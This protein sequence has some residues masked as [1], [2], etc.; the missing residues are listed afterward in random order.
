[1]KKL[2]IGTMFMGLASLGISQVSNDL[3]E[4]VKLSD[5]TI[6]PLNMEY[7]DKV[8]DGPKSE[9]VFT[10][11][12]KASRYNI[13]ESPFFNQRGLNMIH[14]A[15]NKGNILATYDDNG[16]IVSANE[17]YKDLTPPPAVRNAVYKQYPGWDIYGNVYLVSYHHKNGVKKIYKI[18]IRKDGQKKK[19][20]FDF[21]G[22][23]I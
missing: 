8:H 13:K 16:K 11:E 20:R 1:M 7:L 3:L 23:S 18:Q 15:Q 22:N 21:D 12:K 2:L 14:F 10:M 19:L 5:V 17:R 4:K 9:R 6:I